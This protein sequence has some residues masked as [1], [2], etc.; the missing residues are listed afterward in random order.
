[1]QELER[2][3]G[4]IFKN[5]E[6]LKQALTRESAIQENLPQAA[7]QSYQTLEFVGDAALK[8]VIARLLWERSQ[9]KLT[10]G[11]LHNCAQKLIANETILPHIANSLDLAQFIIKGKGETN[12]TSKMKADALEAILGA[13][14]MD[15]QSQENLFY[16]VT[17][18]WKPHLN[19]ALAD[20]EKAR[21]LP[22]PQ[23]AVIMLPAKKNKALKEEQTETIPVKSMAPSKEGIEL[24]S[25]QSTST[26]V[27]NSTPLNPPSPR[28]QR[29]F[30]GLGSSFPAE[31]FEKILP[32]VP[33]VNQ[34]NV[35]KKG[36]TALMKLLRKKE[37]RE[38]KEIPKIEALL[39]YGAL[40]TVK[41]NLGETADALAK[42]H[43]QQVISKLK[44][45]K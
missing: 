37:L 25:P 11:E 29:M 39:K 45:I 12:I 42:K 8:H 33:N 35:G 20:A 4:Y 9:G 26:P 43:D 7:R 15:N 31:K 18:L 13:I 44:G 17:Q 2:K 3:L 32:E 10:E 36:D 14:S 6:L 16:V 22:K 19:K 21:L 38:G 27:S 41:N 23:I 34:K 30:T 1:M 24:L 40:W 5:Q 28:T